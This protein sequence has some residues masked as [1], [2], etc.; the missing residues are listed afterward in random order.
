MALQQHGQVEKTKGWW[1]SVWFDV[2]SIIPFVLLLVVD[3]PSFG[4]FGLGLG[5]C[6]TLK[7]GLLE[8]IV[9]EYYK[10]K[11]NIKMKMSFERGSIKSLIYILSN[12]PKL[13]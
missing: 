7:V 10:L 3:L 13:R 8:L 1:S 4:R 12:V 2:E 11:T 6:T 9:N 5:W